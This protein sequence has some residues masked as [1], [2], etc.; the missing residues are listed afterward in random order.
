MLGANFVEQTFEVRTGL[1]RHFFHAASPE[2][3]NLLGY[4]RHVGRIVGLAAMRHGSEIRAVS[5]DE[6]TIH[7]YEA[8]NLA[9]IGSVL[10][11]ENA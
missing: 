4:E 10:E 11:S 8:C 1:L 3:R 2:D 7:R 6:A 9:Q 5:F